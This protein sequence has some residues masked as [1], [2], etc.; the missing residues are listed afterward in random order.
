MNG[1]IQAHLFG[2]WG[3]QLHQ[4][5]AA[6]AYAEYIGAQLEAPEWLGR[7]VFG[8]NDPYWSCELPRLNDGC[9]GHPPTL[10]WDSGQTNIQLS[11]Y[12]QLQNW[13]QRLSRTKVK[14]WLQIQPSWLQIHAYVSGPKPQWYAA[15][16]L[17]QGD[18]IGHPMYANVSTEAYRAAC[19]EHHIPLDKL[20]WVAQDTRAQNPIFEA[21]G[22]HFL[23]DFITLAQADVI[24]RANST[25][26][27]WAAALSNAEVYA[28]VVGDHVGWYDAPFVKGNWPQV[29]HIDRVGVLITDL[30]LPD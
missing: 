21:E 23:A 10:D 28:P 25:F 5:V 15:A 14:A 30:Y 19:V 7:K 3:N 27:W 22:L 8:L 18:Y 16:H 17:R 29:A 6:R 4:Y 1:I 13:V 9:G 12:F 24:L 11:G 26:S 2:G 20:V